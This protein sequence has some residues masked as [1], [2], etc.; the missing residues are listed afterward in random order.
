[1]IMY[2]NRDIDHKR[3]VAGE[4]EP[5]RHWDSVGTGNVL[6]PRPV[7]PG[8]GSTLVGGT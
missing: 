6:P 8:D 4:G 7:G 3:A 5:G 2:N 1:M